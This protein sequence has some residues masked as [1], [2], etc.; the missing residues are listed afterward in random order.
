MNQDEPTSNG[1][2]Y[3]AW[4]GW[5]EETPFGHLD[6]GERQYF[7]AEMRQVL[8]QRPQIVDVLEIGFGN[9]SFLSYGREQGWNVTGTEL[10]PELVTAGQAL[11]FAVFPADHIDDIPD[12]SIDLI[13]MFDVLEHI[14]QD[15]IVG[16]LS[17]LK[18]KLRPGGV[19]ILRFPN[20]DSWIGNPL[21]NGDPTH[22]TAIGYLKMTY[23]ALQANL[24][25]VAFRGAKRRGFATSVVHGVHRLI[26]GPV[27]G[28][29][30]FLTRAIYF[31]G[32]PVV[33]AT[34]NIVCVLRSNS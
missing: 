7:S 10:D 4:K 2:S 29:V 9:G 15:G 20:A 6:A 24:E 31:P 5:V 19:M 26:A 22:V 11:G 21:Q 13:A 18:A 17:S 25:V 30:A 12:R 16:F 14:P 1:S 34:S 23:F 28:G 27:V 32:L 33:L 8:A 3:V